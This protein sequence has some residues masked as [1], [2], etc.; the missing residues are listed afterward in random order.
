[1]QTIRER[2]TENFPSVLLTLLSMIQALALELLWSRLHDS[3]YLLAGGL[4]AL[5]GWLQAAAV[6]LG[7]LVV[8]VYYTSLVMRFRWLPRTRDSIVPFGIG[9]LEFALVDLMGPERAGAWLAAFALIF[10][11]S[12]WNSHLTYRRAR[13][14]PGNEEFFQD[15][16]PA[17]WR[18]HRLGA[19]VIGALL[20]AAVLCGWRG[21][22]G[23]VE[24]LV[25]AGVCLSMLHQL[26]ES[27]RYWNRM[28]AEE[29]EG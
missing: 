27:R 24:G 19:A 13:A 7:M 9:L 4:T 3:D 20:A 15:V 28:L 25:F 8:W 1:M 11:L 12:L 2:A 6:L 5:V 22:W 23:I 21:S 18:D 26:A 10:T 14:E 16:P 17:T 29:G